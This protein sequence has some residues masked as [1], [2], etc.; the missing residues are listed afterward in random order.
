MLT[1]ELFQIQETT[2]SKENEYRILFRCN[3]THPV[4]K[5]HFPNNPVLPGV[6]MV[7][8]VRESLERVL[9]KKFQLAQSKNIKFVNVV[10]PEKE[11]IL[12]LYLHVTS[13][14]NGLLDVNAT[15]KSET[16][17]FFQYKGRYNCL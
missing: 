2:I 3:A 15:I 13:F 6:C 17:S 16:T 11:N 9:N 1:G 10:N 12:Q 7:Q 5:G 8:F 14:E 4:F